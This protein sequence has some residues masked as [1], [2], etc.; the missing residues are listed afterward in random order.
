MQQYLMWIEVALKLGSGLILGLL[1]VASPRL[2]GLPPSAGAFWPRLL[3]AVLVGVGLAILLQAII[4][5]GSGLGLGGSMAIN[6][7]AAAVVTGQLV[8]GRAATTRRG[9]A[10]LWALVVTL[11][12]LSLVE[13]A[14][15]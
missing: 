4:K 5:P 11:T 13:L 15:I 2:F 10:T 12:G 9:N 6:L 3:A 7:T 8:M 14:Y 1:P